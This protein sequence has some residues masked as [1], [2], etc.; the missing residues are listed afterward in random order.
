MEQV[1]I[2]KF[3]ITGISV[4]T[5][6]Q[7]NQS[8]HDLNQLW[9]HV[10]NSGI[11]HRIPGKKNNKIYCIYTDYK[12]DYQDEYTAIIGVETDIDIVMP[13]EL[14]RVQIKKGNY[15]KYEETGKIPDIVMNLW[16]NIWKSNLKRKYTTDFEVYEE[17]DSA[18]NTNVKV[19]IAV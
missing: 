4:R 16:Q 17:M 5:T 10:F 7:N 8:H 9:Q 2:D 15:I 6:N 3:N 1:T 13:D 19:F 11:L 14:T 18:D 12:S